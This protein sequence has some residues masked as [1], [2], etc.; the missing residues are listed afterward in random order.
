M[1]ATDS[2]LS[3]KAHGHCTFALE[4]LAGDK[5]GA[6]QAEAFAGVCRGPYV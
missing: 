1:I 4:K 6:G 3:C 5:T 2:L